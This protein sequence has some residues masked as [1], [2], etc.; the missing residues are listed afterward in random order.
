MSVIVPLTLPQTKLLLSRKDD[1]MFVQCLVRRKK[2]VL[3]PEEW[4]RQHFI[5]FLNQQLN[6][7]ISR[8]A[9]E[10]SIQYAGLTKRWDIVVHDSDFLPHILVECK[11]PKI[12]ISLDTLY[13]ALTYQKEM[14]GKFIALTNGIDH[15]FFGV[16][17]EKNSLCE[18]TQLPPYC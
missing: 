17:T 2:L 13:Q 12:P 10:K 14:Q 18:L 16:D 4:V 9:V 11:A 3:T 6:Y 5:A 15:A 1:Q 8:I 7:P